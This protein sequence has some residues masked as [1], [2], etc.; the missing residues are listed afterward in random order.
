M[1]EIG[2]G[3]GQHA[4]YFATQMPHLVWH[5][6]DRAANHADINGWLAKAGLAN[7]RAPLSLD[8][9]TSAWPS[10]AVDAV[11]SANTAHIMSWEAV[12]ML[13]SGVGRLLSP[14]GLFLLYGPFNYDNRYSSESNRYFDQRLK[15]RDSQSGIRDFEALDALARQAGMVLQQDDQ[16]PAN[17]HLLCWRKC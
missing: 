11:F 3:T 4:I 8:V 2:S 13:F 15:Q 1:L 7:T 5:T 17:N 16:M 9:A 6:S 10:L 12:T 14:N